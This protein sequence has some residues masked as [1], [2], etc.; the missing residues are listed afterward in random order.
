M[1]D[2]GKACEFAM[3]KA[4][5]DMRG[6]LFD[7][8]YYFQQEHKDVNFGYVIPFPCGYTPP[9][10]ITTVSIKVSAGN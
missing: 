10:N 8:V 3:Q 9:P 2:L 5:D 1:V 7:L 6:D 4:K